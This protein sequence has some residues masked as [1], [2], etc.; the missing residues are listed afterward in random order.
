MAELRHIEL[1]IINVH[2]HITSLTKVVYIG[3]PYFRKVNSKNVCDSMH[4]PLCNVFRINQKVWKRYTDA[5]ANCHKCKNPCFAYKTSNIWRLSE[6]QK[7]VPFSKRVGRMCKPQFYSNALI[8]FTNLL[9]YYSF[10][11]FD[12]FIFYL[13]QNMTRFGSILRT[14][15]SEHGAYIFLLWP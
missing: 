13:E 9:M 10:N 4:P 2:L 11:H 1:L 3:L 7:K 15:L 5:G 12:Q 14:L 6:V 8:K